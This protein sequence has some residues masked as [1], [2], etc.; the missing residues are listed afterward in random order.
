MSLVETIRALFA[1]AAS[2]ASLGNVQEADS[3]DRKAV[4]L[5]T[6]HAIDQAL[7]NARQQTARKV[8]T[9]EISGEELPETYQSAH[10][11]GIVELAG[12]LGGC[13]I[14]GTKYGSSKVRMIR[15]AM[16]DVDAFRHLALGLAS[17]AGTRVA[18][19]AGDRAYRSS[20]VR[21]FW[22]GCSY[23]ARQQ[24]QADHE[25]ENVSQALVVSRQA[26]KD[27]LLKPGETTRPYKPPPIA[28][29][30]GWNSGLVA[31]VETYG[32]FRTKAL[33]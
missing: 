28:R 7:V 25:P 21:G 6:R 26:A 33:A 5:M 9:I 32:S 12:L 3:Y 4:E 17:V 30:Q 10:A 22:A 29:A 27:S 24:I 16:A 8:A 18:M 2:A 23:Q 1:H 20:W 13:G 19:M 15:I 14:V 31:G 11:S